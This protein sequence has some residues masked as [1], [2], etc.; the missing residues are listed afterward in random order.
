MIFAFNSH[1]SLHLRN[2]HEH[3]GQ[4]APNERF[5]SLIP[6]G[7]KLCAACES[8]L[9][10]AKPQT[11]ISLHSSRA[12]H[13]PTPPHLQ[14]L[15]IQ[16]LRRAHTRLDR[17]AADILPALLQQT[18]E[19]IDGEHDIA[20]ELV[21]GH[22]DIAHRHAETEH[23]L[24]L[25]LDRAL[26]LGHLDVEV[27]GVCDRGRELAGLGEPRAQETRDLSHERVRGEEGVVFARELF[28]EFFVL[29]QLFEVVGGHG[30]DAVVFGSVDV[31]LVAEDAGEGERLLVS[32]QFSILCVHGS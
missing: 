17:Q 13:P 27:L 26:D 7:Q 6:L 31:V 16:P 5:L 20:D 30:V 4:H 18:D 23:L 25:E 19:V 8:W 14:Y 15:L 29:V 11:P 2:R 22:A 24:E 9:P 28:D 21:L 10:H 32:L 12:N 1:I 3:R